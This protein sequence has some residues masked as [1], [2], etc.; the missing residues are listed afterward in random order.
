MGKLRPCV[1]YAE[2]ILPRA[3][4]WKHVQTEVSRP[5][6]ICP[7]GCVDILF[8]LHREEAPWLVGLMTTARPSQRPVDAPLLGL[9]L[10]PLL[11]SFWPGLVANTQDQQLS[12]EQLPTDL[13]NVVTRLWHNLNNTPATLHPTL[14]QQWLD[15]IP[16]HPWEQP[17]AN[18]ENSVQSLTMALEVNER[19]L[20]RHLQRDVGLTPKHYLRIQRFYRAL[21]LHGQQ[22][23]WN[24]AQIAAATGYA[25]QAHLTREWKT[26]TGHPPSHHPE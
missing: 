19:Y 20:E 11:F 12:L 4:V 26:F 6:L 13:S 3:V 22:P 9:R 18:A 21:Q 25:D 1:A 14:I 2:V 17:L 23:H 5:R 15:T 10:S 24:W 7:D 8:P 16:Q